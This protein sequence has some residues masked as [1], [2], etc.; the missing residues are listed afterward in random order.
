MH[1]DNDCLALCNEPKPKE[2]N[3]L[4]ANFFNTKKVYL[5]YDEYTPKNFI[6][7]ILME[8]FSKDRNRS[9]RI[10]KE[11]YSNGRALCGEY[12]QDIADTITCQAMDLA[13]NA[14]HPLLISVH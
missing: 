8:F 2:C 14:G 3:S 4:E 1:Y 13:R 10:L 12:Y 9:H 11:V 6:V 7:K 5:H